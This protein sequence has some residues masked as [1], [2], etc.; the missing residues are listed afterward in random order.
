[1]AA[2]KRNGGSPLM[3]ITAQQPAAAPVLPARSVSV[4][5][6][7]LALALAATTTSAIA[8]AVLYFRQPAPAVGSGGNGSPVA[9]DD[10]LVQRGT[11]SP[12]QIAS[13]I[14]HYETP[15]ATP[16]NLKLTPVKRTYDILRQDETG[17]TWKARPMVEDFADEA[18][19]RAEV[20]MKGGNVHVLMLDYLLQ[21]A[22]SY[23]L[24]ADL[25]YED[26]SWEARGMRIPKGGPLMVPYAQEGTFRALAGEQGEVGFRIPYA[27]T[28]NVELSSGFHQHENIVIVECRPT[29]FKWKSVAKD[30]NDKGDV[31]WKAKGVKATEIPKTK[32]D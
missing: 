25:R 9:A 23:P 12:R 31:V 30:P 26:F 32:P 13:D 2:Y 5:T 3:S 27:T 8:F 29:G 22:S 24:K 10:P 4:T 7:V 1:M 11:V 28:P 15:Y 19:K 6:L 20:D 16:P 14:V 21:W 17:F 18:L